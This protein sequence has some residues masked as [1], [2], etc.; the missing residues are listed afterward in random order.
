MTMN[1]I[2]EFSINMLNNGSITNRSDLR[3]VGHLYIVN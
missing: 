1:D 3:L 2:D